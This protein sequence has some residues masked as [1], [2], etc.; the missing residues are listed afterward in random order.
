MLGNEKLRQINRA[1]AMMALVGAVLA[2][3]AQIAHAGFLSPTKKESGVPCLFTWQLQN[4]PEERERYAL[5]LLE[6]LGQP[7]IA[8]SDAAQ[9][10][11][12]IVPAAYSEKSTQG[13]PAPSPFLWQP[14]RPSEIDGLSADCLGCHDGVGAQPVTTVLRNDPFASKL[15]RILPGNDHPIGMDYENYSAL[16]SEYKP[17]LGVDIGMVFVDGKVGCLTCHNPLNQEKGHL[18]MSDR[19]SALCLTCH[20]K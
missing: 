7:P 10:Y 18:V 12:N 11:G 1:V 8:S 4:L 9:M 15:D 5:K 20:R 2:G 14:V 17:L 19:G 6:V 3:V 16:G 13:E